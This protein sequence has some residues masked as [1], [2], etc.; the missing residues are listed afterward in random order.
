MVDFRQFHAPTLDQLR[1]V[2]RL[3][4]SEL[5]KIRNMS[6]TQFQAFKKNFSFACLENI[7]KSEAQD[8]LTSM[9]ALNLKLQADIGNRK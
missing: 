8:L 7:T 6:E 2:N 3:H 5:R 1:F 4:R 9:L